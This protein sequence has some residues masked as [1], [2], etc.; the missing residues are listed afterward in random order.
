MGLRRQIRNANRKVKIVFFTVHA[1]VMYAVQALGAGGA[2]YVLKGSGISE[3]REAIRE[4]LAGGTYVTPSIDRAV[5]KLQMARAG[6]SEESQACLTRHQREVLQLIAEGRTGKEVAAIL[7]VSLR[8]VEFHKYRIL[9]ALGVRTTAD[10]VQYAI[11]H[12]IV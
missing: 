1:D 12:G 10:L 2:G 11:K 4:V 3:I 6:R 9:K 7:N 8:T 5:L